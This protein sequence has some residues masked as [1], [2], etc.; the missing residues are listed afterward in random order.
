M[1]LIGEILL[2]AAIV[3][4]LVLAKSIW[5]CWKNRESN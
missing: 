3:L 4:I 5:R 1:I 2:I